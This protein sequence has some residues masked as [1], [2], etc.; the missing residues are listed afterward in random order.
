MELNLVMAILER[1]RRE[2]MEAIFESMSLPMALTVLGRGTATMELLSLY[3]L[4]P[5]EK[6]VLSTVADAEQTQKLMRAA[7]RKLYI[8]IPG[9]GIMMSVPIK[10]IGG[11]QTMAYLTDNKA[12]TG[13]KP[14]MSFDHELIYTI[15]NEGHSDMVMAAARPTGAT[16]GTVISGKGTGIRKSEKFMGISL[17]DEKDVVMI[18]APADKKAAIMRAIVEKAGVNTPAGALCFSLP[19][20]QVVGLRA[21]DGDEK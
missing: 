8:D 12:P 19:V 18:V 4:V 20:S 6:A 11:G 21:I 15:I 16:G 7:K 9:N 14:K 1:D 5:T 3:G 13:D 2:D 10:S 17:A